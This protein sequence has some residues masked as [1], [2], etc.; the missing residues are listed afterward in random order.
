M[1]QNSTVTC[2][3]SPARP[4]RLDRMLSARS[5]G[6]CLRGEANRGAGPGA[7]NEGPQGLQK[8]LPGAL[9][10]PHR[11]Q[12]ATWVAPQLLQNTASAGIAAPQAAQLMHRLAR[13]V[14][15]LLAA[16]V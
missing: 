4:A 7:V 10:W 2:L 3:S 1:S 8:R 15:V 16:R 11:A 12:A 5:V 9:W 14:R 6:V 13:V